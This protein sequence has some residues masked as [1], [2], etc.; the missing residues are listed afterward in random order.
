M[1][2]CCASR[3]SG[4]ARDAADAGSDSTLPSVTLRPGVT[5]PDWSAV[6]SPRTKEVLLAL[7][8]SDHVQHRWSGYSADADRVRSALLRIYAEVGRAP[9]LDA[10]AARSE[11][12]K[13]AVSSL[14]DTLSKHDLVL[15]DGERIVGAYPF[16]DGDS[17][18]RVK[19]DGRSVNAMCAVDALGIGAMLDCDVAIESRCRH[20]G[21]P[22]RITTR[23]QGRAL[24][25]V[26][27][28][29]A[30]VWLSGR[31]EGG[32]A[33][34]SLCA[35]TA[36][37]CTADHLAEWRRNRRD[38]VP[39]FGLSIEE[40]LEVGRAIFGPILVG[41]EMVER[42]RDSRDRGKD[43]PGRGSLRAGKQGSKAATCST[44]KRHGHAFDLAVIGAGS[45]GF[46]AAIAA[47]ER[48]A[49]VALI[50]HGTIGGTCV[51]IG[52]VP[53][54][55][56][57]R[58]A[59]TL[60]QAKTACR[61]RGIEAHAKIADWSAVMAEKRILAEDLRQAKYVDL[62]PAYD[63][64]TYLEGRARLVNGGVSVNG[65][66]V[67]A[68]KVIIA[69][70]SAPF[71]P[72]IVGL[73]DVPYL[74]STTA[75]ELGHLPVSMIVIGGGVI[76]CELGQMFARMGTKVTLLCRSRLLPNGEPEISDALAGYLQ[77]TKASM[78]CAARH[79]NP[80][81]KTACCI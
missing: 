70:G 59:E 24:A 61:F 42:A 14:L 63:A 5:L 21:S 69:T 17:G 35:E 33:A 10:L 57:I 50:G 7:V 52:C 23:I 34:S 56:M 26:D 43:A 39:G 81:A 47:A 9:S 30:V 31:Y 19:L 27:P 15:L 22:I 32:C 77:E 64:V 62:L 60:H 48:G 8:Q 12:D 78:W 28:Q 67:K 65:D 66:V 74:T 20:C 68:G 11:M 44:T 13:S 6:S 73:T 38:D 18:H 1:S 46:S 2:D 80:S 54:K 58:A 51:N 71:L 40:A 37:F 3:P 25:A 45:A 16:T 29:S 53:S 72:P 36:F 41:V 49:R 75:L 4:L 55:T 79:T 76:G